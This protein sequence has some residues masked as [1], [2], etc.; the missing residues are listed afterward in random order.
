MSIQDDNAGSWSMDTIPLKNVR[1]GM[2]NGLTI[3]TG[4]YVLVLDIL[5][6]RKMV[7]DGQANRAAEVINA[8][9]K[10][11][12]RWERINGAFTTISFSDTVLFYQEPQGFEDWAF[13]DA[14]A[15]AAMILTALLAEGIPAR[16]AIA[17]GELIVRRDDD[18]RHEIFCGRAFNE[19]YDTQEHEKEWIG[20]VICRSAIEPFEMFNPGASETIGKEGRWQQRRD[21]S[22]L[23]N[24][25]IKLDGTYLEDQIGEITVPY[26][27]WN[28]PDFPNELRAFRFLVNT[29]RKFECQGDLTSPIA[30]KYHKTVMFLREILPEGCFEWAERASATITDQ[31]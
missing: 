25:F 20:I 19:A 9:L 22:L 2:H 5:G 15:L 21:G 4:R 6:F 3:K 26:D 11:C 17:F 10:H 28:A 7:E 24:P 8:T 27:Q 18:N 31:R 12:H 29:A 30:I 13:L 23:L 1:C 14:Y 16:G